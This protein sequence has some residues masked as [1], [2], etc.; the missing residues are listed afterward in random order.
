MHA[1]QRFSASSEPLRAMLQ[2]PPRAG[3]ACVWQKRFHDELIRVATA[4]LL[5]ADSLHRVE[6]A[7]GADGRSAPEDW[8]WCS[9]GAAIGASWPDPLVDEEALLEL[10]G[11]DP[12]VAR[13]TLQEFVEE[14]RSAGAMA[15]DD[16]RRMSDAEK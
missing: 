6:R 15:S 14:K 11:R 3:A 8:P 12:E 4:H 16:V 2:P 1:E 5:E 13:R 7:A 10:F 9:Y